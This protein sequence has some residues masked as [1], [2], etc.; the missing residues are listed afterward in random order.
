LTSIVATI[1]P[2]GSKAAAPPDGAD[3]PGVQ[4]VVRAKRAEA[5]RAP[6]GDENFTARAY[7]ERM[8]KV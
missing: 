7:S 6:D 2:A 8:R 4:A 1:A 3:A 5:A